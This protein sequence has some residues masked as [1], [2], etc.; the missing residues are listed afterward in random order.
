MHGTQQDN[1]FTLLRLIAE[2]T[3][4]NGEPVV[5]TDIKDRLEMSSADLAATWQHLKDHNLIKT[6]SLPLAA[7]I[8][9][10]G[11]EELKRRTSPERS[12]D[13][14]TITQDSDSKA[15]HAVI[16]VHGIR[17]QGEWQQ[18]VANC[19]EKYSMD[20]Y[21][22]RYEFFDLFRFLLPI[23]A[24]RLKPVRRVERLIRDVYSMRRYSKISLVCHSFGTWILAKILEQATDIRFHRIIL[25]GSVIPDSFEWNR[26][27]AQYGD[28]DASGFVLN[29]C[30]MRDIW[31]VF[32]TSITSGYGS[33][34]RF[35][36]GNPRVRD[37]FHAIGHSGYFSEDFVTK[38]WLPFLT[39]GTIVAGALDRPTTSWWISLLTVLKLKYLIVA[40]LVMGA[41][42]VAWRSD[43]DSRLHHVS[44]KA[45][46]PGAITNT[47]DRILAIDVMFDQTFTLPKLQSINLLR[48]LAQ[49]HIAITHVLQHP[50]DDTNAAPLVFE[51]AMGRA[52]PY[53]RSPEKANITV[54]VTNRI[55]SWTHWTNL[56]YAAA[57]RF[58][59]VSTYGVGSG[60][61]ADE[62]ALLRRYLATVIPLAALH[63]QAIAEHKTLLRDRDAS[64]EH[65]CLLDFSV[66]K[67]F[68][69]DE[70]RQ[71]AKMC[72]QEEADLTA[73][74][75]PTISSEY[76]AILETVNQNT[77][78]PSGVSDLY[79]G[80][81]PPTA[82]YLQTKE[83]ETAFKHDA[84]TWD[85][86]KQFLVVTGGGQAA[87]INSILLQGESTR[88]V[89]FKDAFAI[90]DRTGRRQD[91][92]ANVQ[93][94]G[95]Y[96][97]VNQ[98]NIPPRASVWL[99]LRFQP[100]L[101]IA[102]FLD[103]WGSLDVTMEYLD[104]SKYT[105]KF[106]DDFV[107]DK[108]NVMVPNIIGARVTPRITK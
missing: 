95:A 79:K 28:V 93:S 33:S 75:G 62:S 19:L 99:E 2:V 54:L 68:F 73:A 84:I 51:E 82:T 23:N 34:G 46:V 108:L 16:L 50:F 10:R 12:G 17:T 65:G 52:L 18:R 45:I 5:V 77:S 14:L 8:N 9:T 103:T 74:F 80:E 20:V 43:L 67:S 98:V 7:C 1:S 66:D 106:D 22:T 64:T 96:Y 90:S 31:P 15:L 21:P 59:V 83:P 70:L 88:S 86:N 71:G 41:F 13:H 6:F 61:S 30:G 105:H 24:F 102:D 94:V 38:Y 101:S 104:G 47:A 91:F 58:A 48:D 25:C 76:K 78:L 92:V 27:R 56:F 89:G 42:A 63:G 40:S 39:H 4:V 87:Q 36:F 69:I 55:L 60:D 32:A 85:I 53:L 11:L 107:R 81:Y 44:P 37:R 3:T 72:P 29:D 97:P 35:G 100:P 57:P 49:K 26:Y